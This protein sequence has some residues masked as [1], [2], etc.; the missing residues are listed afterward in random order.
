MYV[1]YECMHVCMYVYVCMSM[2]VCMYV[3]GMSCMYIHDI[4]DIQ[5]SYVCTCMY[6]CMYVCMYSMYVCM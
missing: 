6:V 4:H 3:P 2:Y 5:H 1:L